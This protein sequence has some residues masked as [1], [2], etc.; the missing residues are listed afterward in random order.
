MFTEKQK[1][2]CSK[3]EIARFQNFEADIN[4]DIDNLLILV[5]TGGLVFSSSLIQHLSYQPILF[6]V[7]WIALVFGILFSLLN[8][9]ITSEKTTF[10][11]SKF[12]KA[13]RENKDFIEV[14]KLLSTI[15]L[16]F[17]HSAYIFTFLG[18]ILL[19]IAFIIKF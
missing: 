11:L 6:K 3:D 16:F 10:Y 2:K 1:I 14:P 5:S 8:R 12:Y 13:D 9:I 15:E 19:A 18:I 17:C 7:S 4:K